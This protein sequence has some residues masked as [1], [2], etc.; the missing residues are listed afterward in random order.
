M[1]GGLLQ[2][3]QG[4]IYADLIDTVVVFT[5]NT[6]IILGPFGMHQWCLK[7]GNSLLDLNKEFKQI[8]MAFRLW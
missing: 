6:N 7:K 5:D 1:L 4:K 3:V 2:T 8:S